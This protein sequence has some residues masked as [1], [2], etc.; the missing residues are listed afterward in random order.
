MFDFGRCHQYTAGDS[1]DDVRGHGR[2]PAGSTHSKYKAETTASIG[3]S[4]ALLA[5]LH[6]STV[7]T[8]PSARIAARTRAARYR[9]L[10]ESPQ[11]HRGASRPDPSQTPVLRGTSRE[12][13]HEDPHTTRS[14]AHRSARNHT[15]TDSPALGGSLGPDAV[16]PLLRQEPDSLRPLP[17]DDLR[18]GSLHDLLLP[19]SGAAPR[20]DGGLRGERLPAHQLGAQ[21]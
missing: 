19:G 17:V 3:T 5:G 6:C 21:T 13:A 7:G 2:A 15:R 14:S 12:N 10:T 16:H 9:R 20:T 1:G 4:F 18:D 11:D 8:A